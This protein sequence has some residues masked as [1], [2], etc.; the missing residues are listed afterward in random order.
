MDHVHFFSTHIDEQ[1]VALLVHE[2]NAP[3]KSMS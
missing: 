3:I 2:M 1:G